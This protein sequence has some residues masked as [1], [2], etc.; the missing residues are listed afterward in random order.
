MYILHIGVRGELDTRAKAKNITGYP[1]QGQNIGF[2][3]LFEE[4]FNRRNDVLMQNDAKK[5]F[6][7]YDC[8]Q[9]TGMILRNAR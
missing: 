3:G 9:V 5:V 2:C 1:R 8:S 7:E 4:I 6:A